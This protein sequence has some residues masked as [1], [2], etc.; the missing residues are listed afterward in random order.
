MNRVDTI[1]GEHR[2]R[3]TKALMPFV[4]AGY[5]SLE[6][7]RSVLPVLEAS[8]ASVVELG[9][10][11][12]DPIADG[13]I[14]AASMHEALERGA[15]PHAI[16]DTVRAIRD[17]TRLALVAMVSHSIVG[18]SGPEAFVGAAADAGIDGLIVPDIDL[19]TAEAVRN[20]ADR[21]GLT[22][23]LLVAPTTCPERIVQI[24]ALCTG[25]V[26]VL[27]RVGIT[28]ERADAPQVA[29]R[30]AMVRAAT[31]LPIACGFGISTA[32]HV[33]AVVAHAD[34]AIVGSAL[35]RRM[36][37]AADPVAAAGDLVSALARGLS[38]TDN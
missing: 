4:T 3:G 21:A 20:L 24:T 32:E 15:T 14:I 13:P 5:P 36:G 22:F 29:D 2:A 12:S 33:A 37:E 26:Y 23:T 1:L 18:R 19:G 7:T 16:F 8:G 9:I 38:S 25:F 11:F 10:P 34:A 28:G 27:A 6:V 17:T 30:V 35:V 31:D